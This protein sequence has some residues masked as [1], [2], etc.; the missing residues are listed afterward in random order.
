MS[1]PATQPCPPGRQPRVSGLDLTV[2]DPERLAHLQ[3]LYDT[4]TPFA[5]GPQAD[6]LFLAALR[7]TDA[8]HAERS[9]LWAHLRKDAGEP[10]PTSPE[11]LSRLPFLHASFLKRHEILSLPRD[12]ITLHLTSSG[13][14]GQRSQLFLDPWSAAVMQEM[15]CRV[16]AHHGWVDRTREVNYLVF[17]YEPHP[18]SSLGSTHGFGYVG[19]LAPA[20]STTFAL[21]HTGKGHEFDPFGCIRAL[22]RYAEEGAPVRIFGYPAFLHAVLERLADMGIGPLHLHPDSLVLL[23]GGWKGHEDRQ[24]PQD[25]LYSAVTERLGIPS[26]RLRDAYGAAEHPLPYIE[27][28]RHHLH[29]STWAR[30]L[31]RAVDTLRP[32]PHGQVGYLQF[33]SPYI[34]S[35]PLHS[36]VMNDLGSL[37]PPE[38]CGCGL[39]TDWMAIH[40]RAGVTRNRSCAVAAAELLG[41]HAPQGAGR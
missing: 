33:V 37:H 22:L 17:G 25:E 5:V 10:A 27:C 16:L 23:G 19:E 6:D 26:A 39:A 35:M 8:W 38:E 31:V 9:P 34:T 15:D 3:L 14:G 2:P 21:R 30:V 1:D 24:I 20:R 18:T 4:L 32:L 7:Q 28:E 12:R 36:V 40:G 41:R 11:D 13:T 29:V